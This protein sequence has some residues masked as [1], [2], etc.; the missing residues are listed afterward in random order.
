M[1][2][3]EQANQVEIINRNVSERLEGTLSTEFSDLL[4]EALS[5]SSEKT[6]SLIIIEN[7]DGSAEIQFPGG[8]KHTARGG[9]FGPVAALLEA[10]KGR[11]MGIKRMESGS[12]KVLNLDAGEAKIVA[13]LN[14]KSE[15]KRNDNT[16]SSIQKQNV[17][18][19]SGVEHLTIEVK[20][21]GKA[22]INFPGGGSHTA[23]G[24]PQGP[25][26]SLIDAYGE[27]IKNIIREDFLD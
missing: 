19:S 11:I 12:D 17:G 7:L 6:D 22:V 26:Q 20:R 8:G 18:V 10:Y 1:R 3:F 9:P 27:R 13:P 16:V 4:S 24:G 21:D 15:D 5:Q 14:K 23:I 25:V 2:I